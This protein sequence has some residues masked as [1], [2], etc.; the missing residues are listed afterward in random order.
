[1]GP[2]DEILHSVRRSTSTGGSNEAQTRHTADLLTR[3]G[4]KRS[5]QIVSNLS[6]DL[7]H[8]TNTVTGS[9]SPR[10]LEPQPVATPSPVNEN[11]TIDR[12][13]NQVQPKQWTD[14]MVWEEG[15]SSWAELPEVDDEEFNKRLEQ[16]K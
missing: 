14:M 11:P 15:S 13:G 5:S 1:M 12:A 8:E 7:M 4:M 6:T 3:H 2:F 9:T 10:P 16:L